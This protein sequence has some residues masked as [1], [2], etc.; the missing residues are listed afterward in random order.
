MKWFDS[1]HR[2]FTVCFFC[3]SIFISHFMKIYSVFISIL[4]SII[5]FVEKCFYWLQRW[6]P[7]C[8]K[9]NIHLE[10]SI[11]LKMKIHKNPIFHHVYCHKKSQLNVYGVNTKKRIEWKSSKDFDGSD[12]ILHESG[13][14]LSISSLC[15]LVNCVCVYSLSNFSLR[16]DCN[17]L[18][19]TVISPFEKYAKCS[20]L[21]SSY[22]IYDCDLNAIVQN[23]GKDIGLNSYIIY[24]KKRLFCINCGVH[25]VHIFVWSGIRASHTAGNPLSTWFH[26]ITIRIV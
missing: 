20:N 6:F 26:A 23:I 8:W 17:R 19:S 4:I 7:I 9:K 15:E 13:S 14:P 1:F 21:Q 5:L 18:H 3:K 10:E 16:L 11:K 24:L 12:Y 25:Q 22:H 2:C